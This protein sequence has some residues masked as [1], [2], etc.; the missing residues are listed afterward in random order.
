MRIKRAVINNLNLVRDDYYYRVADL[1]AILHKLGLNHSIFV[2][3]DAETW[4]CLNYRCGKRHNKK[5][6]KCS[7]CESEVKPPLIKSP[8]TRSGGKGVG[9]RIYSGIELK[10]I[11]KIFKQRI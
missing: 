4:K 1:E 2:I 9:H 5:V 7:R 11:I 10:E 3:R 8:R 6:E